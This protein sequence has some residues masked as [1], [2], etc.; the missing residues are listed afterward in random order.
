MWLTDQ[1]FDVC[2]WA[3]RKALSWAR[4]YLRKNMYMIWHSVLIKVDTKQRMWEVLKENVFQSF[5]ELQEMSKF[6]EILEVMEAR[7]RRQRGLLHILDE[8]YLFFMELE[9][10][11]VDLLNVYVLRKQRENMVEAA[12]FHKRMHEALQQVPNCHACF[13]WLWHCKC[14]RWKGKDNSPT[15]CQATEI[16]RRNV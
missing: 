16:L 13:H 5:D 11:R 2:G 4:T 9:Q 3:V 7:Q 15:T 1:K 10:R 8:V 6:K 14:F 12:T